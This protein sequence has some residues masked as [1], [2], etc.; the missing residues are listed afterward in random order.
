MTSNTNIPFENEYRAK[1]YQHPG[2]EKKLKWHIFFINNTIYCNVFAK[3][4]Q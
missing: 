1:Q 3:L 2:L 4:L